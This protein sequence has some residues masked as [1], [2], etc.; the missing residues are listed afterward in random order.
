[1]AKNRFPVTDIEL[2][3]VSV[4]GSYPTT[5]KA[6]PYLDTNRWGNRKLGGTPV[7]KI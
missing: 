3:G 6:V 7:Q 4:A 2:S 5:G 1:M